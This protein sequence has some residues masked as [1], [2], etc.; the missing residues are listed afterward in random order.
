MKAQYQAPTQQHL[1]SY[2]S[3][4]LVAE[5]QYSEAVISNTDG[6]CSVDIFT[7]DGYEWRCASPVCDAVNFAATVLDQ[8]HFDAATVRQLSNLGFELQ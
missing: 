3:P 2:L 4:V 7:D 6:V 5:G 8:P 1:K